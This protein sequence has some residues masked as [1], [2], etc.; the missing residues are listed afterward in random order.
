MG[1]RFLPH[2]TDHPLCCV[3]VVQTLWV[4]KGSDPPAG[5]F[6]DLKAQD[7]ALA[8]EDTDW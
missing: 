7:L 8:Q 1:T 3:P 4:A 5:P 2:A 6:F